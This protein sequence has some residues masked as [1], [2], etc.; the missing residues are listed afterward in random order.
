[1]H[2]FRALTSL[3][4]IACVLLKYVAWVILFGLHMA[5]APL[6][7]AGNTGN[8]TGLPISAMS[9]DGIGLWGDVSHSARRATVI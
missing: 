5:W 9:T 1:M 8:K 2:S 3:Q 4:T 7:V 6:S